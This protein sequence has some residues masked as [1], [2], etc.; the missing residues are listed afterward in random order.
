MLNAL[1]PAIG[2]VA[3]P[4]ALRL[5]R[6]GV[7]PDAVTVLGAVGVVVS[8]LASSSAPGGVPAAF[9]LLHMLVWGTAGLCANV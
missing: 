7:S 9:G 4:V 8:G 3:R 6:A 1:R 2:R 5:L